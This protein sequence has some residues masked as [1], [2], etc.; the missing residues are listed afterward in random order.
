MDQRAAFTRSIRVGGTGRLT[1]LGNTP[2]SPVKAKFSF[3]SVRLR[4]DKYPA[5]F[6]DDVIITESGR[7]TVTSSAFFRAKVKISEQGFMI[8]RGDA[9]FRMKVPDE[10]RKTIY[11]SGRY[12]KG[13]QSS[14]FGSI[15]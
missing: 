4:S 14:E 7:I 5:W 10:L 8:V 13:D 1:M 2:D 11:V 12:R 9:N 3:F 15:S 6:D